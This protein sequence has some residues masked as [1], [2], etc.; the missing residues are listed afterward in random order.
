VL[1][2][3]AELAERRARLE[4]AG[5]FPVPPSQTPWQAI[6]RDLIGQLG[7]GA[8]LEGSEQFQR[9]AQTRG[10]PRDSH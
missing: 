2:S 9:I 10:L 4:A 8:I 5:G 7:S 3:D 1:I 6:Q